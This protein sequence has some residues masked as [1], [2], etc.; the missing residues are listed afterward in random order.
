MPHSKK[1]LKLLH[2]KRPKQHVL[3]AVVSL[4]HQAFRQWL[5]SKFPGRFVG[6]KR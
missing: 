5:H 4:G 2:S 1:A 6:K 3:G